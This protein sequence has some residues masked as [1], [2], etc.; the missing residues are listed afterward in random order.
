MSTVGNYMLIAEDCLQEAIILYQNGK[1]RGACG[2]AYYA[3]FDAIRALLAT[4]RITTKSHA[5]VRGL[6][7][8][9]F[10]KGHL[11]KKT[12]LY[13]TSYSNYVRLVSR[14]Q[15]KTFQNQMPRKPLT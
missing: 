9:N 1:F 11:S 6:F 8:A 2:R 5:A 10:I 12:R 4:K 3:Y 15:M 7:S 13:S 14:I